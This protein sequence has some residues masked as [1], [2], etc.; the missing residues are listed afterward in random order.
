MDRL[1]QREGEARWWTCCFWNW[2]FSAV[3]TARSLHT[4]LNDASLNFRQSTSVCNLCI[5][6]FMYSALYLHC[7]RRLAVFPS[8]AGMSLTK[9][10]D[11]KSRVLWAPVVSDI[12]AGDGKTSTLLVQCKQPGCHLPNSP[13]AA[14]LKLFKARKSF[15]SDI[16]AG[17][18]KT[19]NLFYSVFYC[20]C[21]ELWRCTAYQKG[22]FSLWD[23]R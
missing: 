11:W 5:L 19:A 13:W 10:G 15:V 2:P 17:N 16:P 9:L 1:Y 8:P 6:S 22:G 20:T 21:G 3:I 18:G 7:K 12:P 14:I 4:P 23:V